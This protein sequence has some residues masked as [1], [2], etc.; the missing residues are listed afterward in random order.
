[1][2]QATQPLYQ[3][4]AEQRL[5]QVEC[6]LAQGWRIQDP[7]VARVHERDPQHSGRRYELVLWCAG[8]CTVL[9]VA[10][11]A[12]VQHFLRRHRLRTVVV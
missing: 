4:T 11:S 5:N 9:A 8:R 2:S 12:A 10:E 3:D 6:W 1:M 7:V